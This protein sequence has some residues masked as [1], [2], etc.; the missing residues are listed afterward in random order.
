MAGSTR[1]LDELAMLPAWHWRPARHSKFKL[2]LL[3][4]GVVRFP[5]EP[6][7]CEWSIA[8][9]RASLFREAKWSASLEAASQR[10]QTVTL[11]TTSVPKRFWPNLLHQSARAPSEA[12]TG[13]SG[14]SRE[15]VF[16]RLS[17]SY[18][19]RPLGFNFELEQK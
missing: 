18:R 1:V 8:E 15:R 14:S 3:D 12:T 13:S 9:R 17:Q 5:H 2:S 4:D 16:V 19:A 11:T 10:R 7:A 6:Q